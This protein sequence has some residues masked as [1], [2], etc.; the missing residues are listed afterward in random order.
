MHS[1]NVQDFRFELPII[2]PSGT[3]LEL[4][5][6]HLVRI[7]LVAQCDRR[8]THNVCT[9]F[10]IVWLPWCVWNTLEAK[11]DRTIEVQKLVREAEMRK[12]LTASLELEVS[13]VQND[14]SLCKKV[15]IEHM[16]ALCVLEVLDEIAG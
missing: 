8:T 10:R 7:N 5:L 1:F 13:M 14:E 16:L 9:A 3:G 4:G 2:T 15:M 12:R 6:T 11:D